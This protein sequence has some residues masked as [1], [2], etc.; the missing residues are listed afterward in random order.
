MPRVIQTR[1]INS[2]VD[3][4]ASAA[5]IASFR[6]YE[7]N[8]LFAEIGTIERTQKGEARIPFLWYPPRMRE[9]VGER[10]IGSLDGGMHIIPTRTYEATVAV[11]RTAVEDDQ[12][13]AIERA[14]RGLASEYFRFLHQSYIDIIKNG[15]LLT[16]FD[17]QPLLSSN[18]ATRGAN[19]VNLVSQPLSMENLSAGVRAMGLY[20]EPDGRPLGMRPTHL[21]VGPANEYTAK[22]L[23]Q[24]QQL[25]MSGDTD[26]VQGM[27]NPWA[28]TMTVLVSSYITNGDWYL[29][30][31][32]ANEYRPAIMVERSDVPVEFVAHT[33]PDHESV[34]RRDSYE[35]GTRARVGFGAGAWYAVYASQ[36]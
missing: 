27:A 30:A 36:V 32:G 23:V 8:D 31:A 24:S 13:G 28:G 22:N 26:R 20:T 33:S 5:F 7:Q 2:A 10:L 35:Y 4:G 6:M 3:A 14:A 18:A 19:N 1:G 25:I 29:I 12:Y 16:T 15:A 34:F 11:P 21:L 17:G 9:W